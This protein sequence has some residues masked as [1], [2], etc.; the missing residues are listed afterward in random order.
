MIPMDTGQEEIGI[1]PKCG[2]PV[3]ER[4]KLYHCADRSCSFVLFKDNR[5]LASMKKKLTKKMVK[6]FLKEGK[7]YVPDLYS[8][9]KNKTFGAMIVMDASG[10]YPS[11]A[12]VFDRK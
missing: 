9:K 7:T 3:F 11:F 8:Q 5:Y 10:K 2:Q 1:C 12:L 4:D 6:D